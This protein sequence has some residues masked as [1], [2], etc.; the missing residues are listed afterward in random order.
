NRAAS[1]VADASYSLYLSHWFVLSALG[2]A[3]GALQLPPSLNWAARGAG[4][5]VA[6]AFAIACFRYVEDPI[7]RWLRPRAHRTMDPARSRRWLRFRSGYS[8]VPL[9]AGT[10]ASNVTAPTQHDTENGQ[11][12]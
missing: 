6:V 1:V 11:W 4:I 3:L 12:R 9:E 8:V 7:D 10:V 5:V 2:K